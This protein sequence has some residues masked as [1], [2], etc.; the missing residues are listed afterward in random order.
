MRKKSK[1]LNSWFWLISCIFLVLL[2]G[3][4]TIAEI[5]IQNQLRQ[6]ILKDLEQSLNMVVNQLDEQCERELADIYKFM[7]DSETLIQVENSLMKEDILANEVLLQSEMGN[8]VNYEEWADVCA[9]YAPENA[10]KTLLLNGTLGAEKNE[11]LKDILKNYVSQ[12]G[13]TLPKE[14]LIYVGDEPCIIE[15]CK[16]RKGYFFI[17]SEVQ[18]IIRYLDKMYLSD[19]EIFLMNPKGDILAA[20]QDI[21]QQIDTKMDGNYVKIGNK[22]Y[23][24][25]LIE[26]SKGTYI[27]G[28][29][30][31]KKEISEGMRFVTIV[32]VTAVILILVLLLL[33]LKIV[34]QQMVT[35]LMNLTDRM[36]IVEEG[37]WE[38]DPVCASLIEEYNVVSESFEHM[39]GEIKN[40]KIENYEKELAVQKLNFQS[41]QM[42]VK[43]HFYL[44]AFNIIYSMAEVKDF[45]TIQKL[46][47]A[48]VEY[49]RYMFSDSDKLVMLSEELKHVRNYI[50]IQ[51]IRFLGMIEYTEDVSE[52]Y[53]KVMLPPFVLQGFVENSIKYGLRAKKLNH[54]EIHAEVF[55]KYYLKI[56][57]RDDG[58]G[59]DEERMEMLN[60][61]VSDIREIENHIG[62]YNAKG[63][64]LH[65]FGN[66]AKI[67]LHNDHGAVVD[68]YI[69]YV[70]GEE[71]W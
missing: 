10:N 7:S 2:I 56:T 45:K 57:I 69:P 25:K 42:Q 20:S 43:P 8:F 41:L 24:L 71:A 15:C 65:I 48:M 18:T 36:K 51:K 44:N 17:V 16:V 40:L 26:N 11:R 49:S 29:M 34:H 67:K 53:K 62:I 5:L 46:T 12:N 35:P 23:L 19:G 63:R 28:A 54:L 68:I 64:L 27:I 30:I 3:S 9:Y 55:R 37:Q 13:E 66:R 52:K 60:K 39:V 31:P 70:G 58:P 22:S 4:I 38:S 32:I 61:E 6:R 59:F 47:M 50:E 14:D 33:L 21:N 1:K